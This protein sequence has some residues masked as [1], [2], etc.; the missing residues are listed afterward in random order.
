[1]FKYAKAFLYTRT[2]G[3]TKN[4][5]WVLSTKKQVSVKFKGI[6]L[7]GA[8]SNTWKP[9]N[10]D[11]SSVISTVWLNVDKGSEQEKEVIHPMVEEKGGSTEF[12]LKI[13]VESGQTLD[14]LTQ[15]EY[16]TLV[17]QEDSDES[18]EEQPQADF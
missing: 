5:V 11:T 13:E 8:S 17:E 16:E 3:I 4:E 7:E 14:L 6:A 2:S 12:I 15:Q 1:M 9:G 18:V 10:T